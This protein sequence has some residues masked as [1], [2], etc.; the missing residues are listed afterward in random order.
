MAKDAE[1]KWHRHSRWRI[2]EIGKKGGVGSQR[3]IIGDILNMN[4]DTS[5]C[6]R[7]IER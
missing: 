5:L 1:K 6:L 3:D 4:T 7:Q 2:V